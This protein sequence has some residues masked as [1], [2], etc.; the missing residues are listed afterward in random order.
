MR[1]PK[2]PEALL[3]SVCH[4]WT[5]RDTVPPSATETESVFRLAAP[6]CYCRDAAQPIW[7]PELQGGPL[8]CL[9]TMRPNETQIPESFIIYVPAFSGDRAAVLS[10]TTEICFQQVLFYTEH[11][12][13]KGCSAFYAGMFKIILSNFSMW[14]FNSGLIFFG[15]QKHIS[16]GVECYMLEDFG[17]DMF[18]YSQ[19]MWCKT[20][21]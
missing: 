12:L 8:S 3:L 15:K 10:V 16:L 6:S 21:Q 7:P 19:N 18:L 9:G 4:C 14:H 1:L 17:R 13:Y 5:S 20:I 11:G 2:L